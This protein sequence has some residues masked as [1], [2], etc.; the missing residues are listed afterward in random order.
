MTREMKKTVL[1]NGLTVV[2]EPNPAN[3]SAAIGFFVRTGSRDENEQESGVSHFL[4][5]MMFKGTATRSAEDITFQL[6]NIGAQANAF[7][8]EENTVYYGAVI[9][10]HLPAMQELLSDML[11]P[12]ID[13]D[14]FSTEKNVILE[15][16]ALY[17]DRPTHVL[18]EKAYRTFYGTHPVGNSVLGSTDS[19]SALTYEQMRGYFERRYRPSNMTL[20]CAGKFDWDRLVQEADKWCGAWKDQETPRNLPGHQP[21]P[22]QTILKRENLSQAHVVLINKGCSAQDAARYP[23]TVLS[24][25][26]GDS[27]GSKMY[28]DL[29]DTGIA[30][31][32]SADS[33]ERDGVGSFGA[34][35]STEPARLDE[36]VERMRK[37]LAEPMNFSDGDLERSKTKLMSRIVLDGELPMGRL[38]SMGLEYAYRRE[39][40]RLEVVIDRVRSITRKDIEVALA[41]F[42]WGEWSECRMIPE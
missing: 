19:I 42:P 30:E 5:H 11:R 27:S 23:L 32:A 14:E 1:S 10:E 26:L 24:S 25:I 33:D 39:L 17:Q 20:V 29:V 12:A 37:I 34:F 40:T 36:V 28:W 22:V 9:P 2:G 6:G 35:A 7:T 4:E 3:V 21:V 38:M 31:S 41:E 15:E 8:S 18:F 13:P 16:I